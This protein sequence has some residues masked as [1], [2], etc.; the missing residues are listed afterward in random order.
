MPDVPIAFFSYSREDSEFALRLANDL[1]AA[2]SN[3]WIDQ[4]DIG[5][6]QL[7]DRV[8]QSAL[9]E[10]PCVLLILSP[11]S[12]NSNNVLDEVSYALDKQK[13]IIPVL[14]RD[15]E[16]PFRV[17]RFQHLDFRTDY[18]RMV[19]ELRKFLHASV[20]TPA[21]MNYM[22]HAQTTN[23]WGVRPS[24]A[25]PSSSAPPALSAEAI[26]SP[27]SLA[28]SRQLAPPQAPVERRPYDAP[29]PASPSQETAARQA[30]SQFPLWVKIVIPAVV[31]LILVVVLMNLGSNSGRQG[32][33]TNSAPS[34]DNMDSDT[35]GNPTSS[36]TAG[37]KGAAGSANAPAQLV[38]SML[39]TN[40]LPPPCRFPAG[41]GETEFS[42]TNA[43]VWYI[44]EF[45]GGNPDDQWEVTWFRGDKN[46]NYLNYLTQPI[47]NAAAGHGTYCH[48]LKVAGSEVQNMPGNW[49][50]ELDRNDEKVDSQEFVLQ[51]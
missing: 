9:E 27:A 25:F 12:A 23:A 37:T 13:N 32:K 10:C 29:V 39:T 6:G 43:A 41:S 35:F 51:R 1:R 47:K 48:A 24:P 42:T 50:V 33:N 8:V 49:M 22:D 16:I 17:R 28:Q 31:V 4:L 11:A 2:G 19:Q 34:K 20:A 18:E 21:A 44:F 14:Y 45:R 15:C 36:R 40:K 7:W 5:P 46:H 30:P 26:E 38:R 3:V